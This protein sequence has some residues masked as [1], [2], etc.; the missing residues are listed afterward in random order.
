M[1]EHGKCGN[2]VCCP[3]V[4]KECY[5]LRVRLSEHEE[6][7]E[8]RRKKRSCPASDKSSEAIPALPLWAM[9]LDASVE[10]RNPPTKR[11]VHLM[12]LPSPGGASA[13][14]MMSLSRDPLN[15]GNFEIIDICPEESGQSTPSATYAPDDATDPSDSRQVPMTPGRDAVGELFW[16]GSADPFS[17]CCTLLDL[18]YFACRVWRGG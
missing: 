14:K 5:G 10:D 6:P 13:Q 3:C 16:R 7:D 2:V 12:A 4:N 9:A 15:V 8:E 18:A 17:V 11:G 1:Y